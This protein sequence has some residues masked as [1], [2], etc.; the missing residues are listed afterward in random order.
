MAI[1]H[2][3]P[4]ARLVPALVQRRTDVVHRHLRERRR[5]SLLAYQGGHLKEVRPLVWYHYYCVR[6]S[7]DTGHC[8]T[9]AALLP[10]RG[11]MNEAFFSSGQHLHCL[12]SS[13][14]CGWAQ[15]LDH[16]D[17]SDTAK[18]ARHSPG[19]NLCMTASI[20]TSFDCNPGLWK[21]RTK[22]YLS[23]HALSSPNCAIKTFQQPICLHAGHPYIPTATGALEVRCRGGGV[24]PC[25]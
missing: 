11:V 4:P 3:L 23:T 8:V 1:V 20:I 21:A 2:G 12:A 5:I 7:G 14:H 25:S 22:A 13:T 16:C 10:E 6:L 18:T 19:H 24:G 9:R 15:H 17:S